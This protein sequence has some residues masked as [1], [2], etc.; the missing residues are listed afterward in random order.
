MTAIN[1]AANKQEA[2][3]KLL[4][5]CMAE[6]SKLLATM[7]TQKPVDA[8]RS[9]AKL[10]EIVKRTPK[11]PLEFKKKLLTDARSFECIANTRAADA[12]LQLAL[13]KARKDDQTE[14][15]RLVSEARNFCNK[16]ISLG[17]ASSFRATANRKIEIIMMTGGVENKGP[18]I[19]K[20]LD[21]APKPTSAKA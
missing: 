15:N 10:D 18:T 11:L 9:K 7:R 20:P 6:C 2:E 5:A 12:A 21:T 1:E 13:E 4:A 17:A 19:A 3:K 8:E 14:R 16:A